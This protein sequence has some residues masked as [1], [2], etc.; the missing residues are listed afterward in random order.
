MPTTRSTDAAAARRKPDCEAVRLNYFLERK[1]VAALQQDPRYVIK[2]NVTIPTTSESRIAVR[3]AN[4]GYIGISLHSDSDANSTTNVEM[5][6]VDTT[7]GWAGAYCFCWSDSRSPR[8]RRRLARELRAVELVLR[9][10][11]HKTGLDEIR[12]VTI[13]IIDGGGDPDETDDLTISLP[14]IS[15]HFD[16]SF[17]SIWVD[18]S[19]RVVSPKCADRRRDKAQCGDGFAH[20]GGAE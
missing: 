3:R 8:A 7:N 5:L 9:S 20:R 13:G 16:I 17:P 14:E 18:A 15:D 10:H 2:R 6:V 12:T 4:G 1:L 11:L 19:S